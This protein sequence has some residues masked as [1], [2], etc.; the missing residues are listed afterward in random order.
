M[1]QQPLPPML[2]LLFSLRNLASSSKVAITFRTDILEDAATKLQ[3][4]R[5]C[6]PD[7][8]D[9][10][11]L[12]RQIL[13]AR[14]S[15]MSNVGGNGLVGN[16]TLQLIWVALVCRFGMEKQVNHTFPA[17]LQAKLAH[18]AIKAILQKIR[19]LSL[20]SV[21]LADIKDDTSV[22]YNTLSAKGPQG[23]SYVGD[24][25]C[26]GATKTMNFLFPELYVML[27]KWVAKI[28]HLYP[29]HNNFEAYW[30]SLQ[31]CQDELRAWHKAHGSLGSLVALDSPP[32]STAIRVF[33][34]CATVMKN[35]K[36]NRFY[37]SKL[38]LTLSNDGLGNQ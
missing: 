26:V 30:L 31:R 3:A 18:P 34:K 10:N 38:R 2:K 13:D 27:D 9:P 7:S 8:I 29:D 33:D 6:Y 14:S 23:L 28:V 21:K 24:H 20:D 17:K 16:R 11:S 32:P 4:W 22:L 25:F 36:P 12:Y 35:P 15:S 37:Q 19:N 1:T 5:D